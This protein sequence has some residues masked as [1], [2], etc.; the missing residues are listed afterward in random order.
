MGNKLTSHNVLA[1]EA[2][3]IMEGASAMMFINSPKECMADIKMYFDPSAN[4]TAPE[5]GLLFKR[6]Q[7]HLKLGVNCEW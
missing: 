1:V 2:T 7:G 3:R 6:I 5:Y 4:M